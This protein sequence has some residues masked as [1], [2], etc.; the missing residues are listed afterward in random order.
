VVHGEAGGLGYSSGRGDCIEEGEGLLKIVIP[1]RAIAAVRMTQRSKYKDAQAQRYLTYKEQV[2]W[3]TKA[4]L[5]RGFQ[6][7]SGDVAVI[8]RVY[9]LPEG[10]I[11]DWDNYA[12]SIC[13]GLKGV[14]WNDDAQ[15]WKGDVERIIRAGVRERVE[16]EVYTREEWEERDSHQFCCKG[17]CCQ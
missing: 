5:P 1:G 6:L 2:G 8:A 12:K 10:H 3:Q 16:I 15:V 17:A 7:F 14:A 4:Q 9:L 13:D 11:G